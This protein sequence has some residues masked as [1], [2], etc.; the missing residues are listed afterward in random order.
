MRVAWEVSAA[1]TVAIAAL[2]LAPSVAGGNLPAAPAAPILAPVGTTNNTTTLLPFVAE[3][4]TTGHLPAFP[5]NLTHFIYI[6]REN[7]VFDDYLG[8]CAT[9]V[10]AS[11]NGGRDYYLSPNHINDT[12]DLHALARN[13]SVFDN[14]YSSVDPYS[15]EAHA[16]IFSA[17]ATT[18]DSCAGLVE[19]IGPGTEWSIYNSTSV[20]N[21][22]CSFGED[23]N[24]QTYPGHGT[25]FDRFIARNTTFLVLGDIIW[26]LENPDCT[27]TGIAGIPGS[28]PGNAQAIENVSCAGGNGWWLDPDTGAETV[29]PV[30]NPATGVPQMLDVCEYACGVYGSGTSTNAFLDQY[31]ANNFVSFV[32]DY[33][34]PTYTFVELFDDHPGP[35]CGA[36]ETY[37]TCIQWND[38]AMY[39]IVQDVMKGGSAYRNNTVIVIQ[40]DD[41]QNGQNGPDHV[42]NGRR[43]PFVVV[44]PHPIMRSGGTSCGIVGES[45]C[46][47]VVHPTTNTSNVLAVMERVEMNVD[48]GIFAFSGYGGATTFP[49]EENDYLAE[50]N[51]L[52]PLW[53]CADPAVRCNTGIPV[54][55]GRAAVTPRTTLLPEGGTDV[56]NATAWDGNDFP[57][58]NAS[59][60]WNLSNLALAQLS[61]KTGASVTLT[62]NASQGVEGVCVTATLDASSRL[63]CTSV[64]VS[65][66]PAP[67]V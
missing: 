56:L 20:R 7:H 23:A 51:P 18:A 49:M 6:V 33:G 41:T 42:N 57:L 1:L 47:L 61:S 48:P 54:V 31:V 32:A 55:V 64:T 11:C 35:Q 59:F 19:G 29:P 24:S 12:P 40:E 10:N 3:N 58:S 8:D 13:Y 63:A 25:Q 36:G 67:R 60:V 17:N 43:I 5:T 9:T 22:D 65:A 21:G 15:A 14:Y 2:V 53:N 4:L 34:L 30:V 39:D 26:E 37:D 27:L 46:G 38:A 44:A 45:P 16:F 66:A 52:E 28:L 50:G 62:A